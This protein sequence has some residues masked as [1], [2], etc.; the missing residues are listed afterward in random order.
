MTMSFSKGMIWLGYE[1]NKEFISKNLCIN[2]LKPKLHCKGSCQ[3]MKKIAEEEREDAPSTF[4]KLK[5]GFSES[6]LPGYV[7]LSLFVKEIKTK[8]NKLPRNSSYSEPVFPVFHPP[9]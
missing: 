6:D 4:M 2:K 5:G 3:L 9:A 8:H 7:H 1:L